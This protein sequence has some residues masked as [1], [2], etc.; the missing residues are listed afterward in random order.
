MRPAHYKL[1]RSHIDT[2]MLVSVQSVSVD[3]HRLY[4][5]GIGT[6][7]AEIRQHY[8]LRFVAECASSARATVSS[9]GIAIK[10]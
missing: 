4:E 5:G 3:S 9:S 2:K 6:N 7:R 1:F 10:T 8:D